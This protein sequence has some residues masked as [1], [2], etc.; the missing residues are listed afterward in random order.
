MAYTNNPKKAHAQTRRHIV[1][2]YHHPR[3]QRSVAEKE[4]CW[5]CGATWPELHRIAEMVARNP[6]RTRGKQQST[7]DALHHIFVTTWTDGGTSRSD[8]VG[9]EQ[10]E[11]MGMLACRNC[12]TA[13][14][15]ESV[16][17]HTADTYGTLI[18]S[19]FQFPFPPPALTS[20]GPFPYARCF[21]SNYPRNFGSRRVSVTAARRE[22]MWRDATWQL[23]ENRIP[24]DP[25]FEKFYEN[26]LLTPAGDRAPRPIPRTLITLYD[27]EARRT[28]AGAAKRAR[29]AGSPA[30]AAD[31][32][33]AAAAAAERIARLCDTLDPLVCAVVARSPAGAAPAQQAALDAI[34]NIKVAAPSLAVALGSTSGGGANAA[35]EEIR[36]QAA[37]AVR[38]VAGI[39]GLVAR[40]A[41]GAL[42]GA[43]AGHAV[44]A[45]SALGYAMGVLHDEVRTVLAGATLARIVEQCRVIAARAHLL[46]RTTRTAHAIVAH[47][48]EP[49]DADSADTADAMEHLGT[50]L[51][52]WLSPGPGDLARRIDAEARELATEAG[53]LTGSRVVG[54]LF[55]IDEVKLAGLLEHCRQMMGP[56][57][58]AVAA[59]ATA[60]REIAWFRKECAAPGLVEAIAAYFP[61]GVYTGRAEAVQRTIHAQ[62]W[63]TCARGGP[64]AAPALLRSYR[65]RETRAVLHPFIPRACVESAALTAVLA[66]VHEQRP[67]F[68]APGMRRPLYRLSA[69][70]LI[71][72]KRAPAVP[73]LAPE[74]G[75]TAF[76]DTLG[77]LASVEPRRALLRPGCLSNRAYRGLPWIE[78]ETLGAEI[79]DSAEDWDASIAPVCDEVG[80][81]F[82]ALG[83]SAAAAW[84]G[85]VQGMADY[86]RE[87]GLSVRL[88]VA[89]EQASVMLRSVDLQRRVAT[90]QRERPARDLA[91]LKRTIREIAQSQGS[92]ADTVRLGVFDGRLKRALIDETIAPSALHGGVRTLRPDA[93]ADAAFA[94]GFLVGSAAFSVDASIFPEIPCGVLAAMIGVQGTPQWF[95]QWQSIA[96]H[97]VPQETYAHIVSLHYTKTK[98]TTAT[99]DFMRHVEWL[100]DDLVA[101]TN[102]SP[103]AYAL[104]S[105][106]ACMDP[107]PADAPRLARWLAL[108]LVTVDESPALEELR[109]G[110]RTAC[111]V[112]D[113]K[114]GAD[115]DV[116]TMYSTFVLGHAAEADGKELRFPR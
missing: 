49:G 25:E 106:V 91:E 65:P 9:V 52:A 51:A 56:A 85:R 74:Y 21:R 31:A 46:A 87:E 57:A 96:D 4:F 23:R 70:A 36:A 93:P 103:E 86:A 22:A 7:A 11:I 66:P 98:R 60:V 35:A 58:E 13:I 73:G 34:S 78:M 101:S 20:S 69:R 27:H 97:D 79:A 82:A 83:E 32:P 8:P 71:Y 80:R 95:S 28:L 10:V 100:A 1:R 59:V 116:L 89:T 107:L 84:G 62:A 112:G 61:D 41:Q 81:A 18:E 15:R 77:A 88:A 111:V 42:P 39:A 33:A 26:Y 45:A 67:F 90:A 114:P 64:G 76:M 44:A 54:A 43:P 53:A 113:I 109:A 108:Q 115:L 38:V 29:G 30:A 5:Y 37:S 47:L 14:Q 92:G 75:T 12:A 110:F 6:S 50:A 48:P 102:H 3:G 24:W 105:A 63:G 55:P 17:P 99:A 104:L 2:F 72:P 94:V 19:R 40:L 16:L 68:R